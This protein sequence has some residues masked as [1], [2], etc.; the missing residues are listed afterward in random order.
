[1]LFVAMATNPGDVLGID[2]MTKATVFDYAAL[3][4][5]TPLNKPAGVAVGSGALER[6]L[7][8]CCGDGTVW[9]I[10]R[11][12]ATATLIASGGSHGRAARCSINQGL[13]LA[14]TDRIMRRTAP[15]ASGFGYNS[16]YNFTAVA[17]GAGQ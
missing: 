3:N 9:Q 11:G 15:A 6:D 4:T 5:S 2:A 13:L 17:M 8:V 14:Q 16:P 7:F 1:M 10:D 12:D